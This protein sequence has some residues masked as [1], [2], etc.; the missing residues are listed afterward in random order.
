M[1]ENVWVNGCTE[2]FESRQSTRTVRSMVTS[3]ARGRGICPNGST[4][5][6]RSGNKGDV[7]SVTTCPPAKAELR[8]IRNNAGEVLPGGSYGR[9]VVKRARLKVRGSGAEEDGGAARQAEKPPRTMATGMPGR[10]NEDPWTNASVAAG[11]TI[12]KKKHERERKPQCG[13]CRHCQ[14]SKGGEKLLDRSPE[15]RKQEPEG[16]IR[17]N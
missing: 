9:R 2:E 1:L 15:G 3:P 5:E 7:H 4:R 10:R 6:V 13:V 8:K 17:A 11:C 16:G 12:P 14:D